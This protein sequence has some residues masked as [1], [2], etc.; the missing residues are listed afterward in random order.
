MGHSWKVFKNNFSKYFNSFYEYFL[1][2][3]YYGSVPAIIFYGTL[4]RLVIVIIRSIFEALQ[5]Y[6]H[7]FMGHD[8]WQGGASRSRLHGTTSS[9]HGWYV[10]KVLFAIIIASEIRIIYY[11]ELK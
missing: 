6:C 5:S 9:R 1:R 7:G 8:D 4:I 3:I 2:A 10:L 11:G